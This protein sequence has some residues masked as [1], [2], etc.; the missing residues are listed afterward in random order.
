M[1][2]RESIIRRNVESKHPGQ[3]NETE[4]EDKQ[5]P[6]I[7]G[8]TWIGPVQIDADDVEYILSEVW[9]NRC[10]VIGDSL[11]SS[12]ELVR[13]DFSKPSDCQNLVVMCSKARKMFD[14][15]AGETGDGRNS[16]NPDLRARIEYRLLSCKLESRS[17]T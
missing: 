5:I 9:R 11:G 10:A 13:W 14:D 1:K 12:L 4:D 3:I 15:L 17:W 8:G 2:N 16:V 6:L 7:L